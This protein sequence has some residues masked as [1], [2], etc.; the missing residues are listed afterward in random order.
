M[1]KKSGFGTLSTKLDIHCICHIELLYL[2]N[3]LIAFQKF[4]IGF[5]K[6]NCNIF[7]HEQCSCGL[8]NYFDVLGTKCSK[9]L[10]TFEKGSLGSIAVP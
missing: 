7:D 3:L 10:K 2:E 5:Y 9:A 8:R 4:L 1:V 6:Y